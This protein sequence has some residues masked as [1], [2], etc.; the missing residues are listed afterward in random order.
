MVDIF[1][2]N[3]LAVVARCS[4]TSPVSILD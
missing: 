1:S 4:R 3:M 2:K